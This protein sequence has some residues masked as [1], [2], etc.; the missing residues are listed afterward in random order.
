MCVDVTGFSCLVDI[1]SPEIEERRLVAKALLHSRA[2]RYRVLIIEGDDEM[3]ILA[4]KI[5]LSKVTPILTGGL[6]GL[7]KLAELPELRDDRDVKF[8][9]DSDY[10][11]YG[12]EP[13]VL[14]LDRE[15]FI[16]SEFHDLMTDL[17]QQNPS[18]MRNM[19]SSWVDEN[20]IGSR[21]RK[22]SFYGVGGLS[23]IRADDSVSPFVDDVILTA[24]RLANIFACIRYVTLKGG[25]GFP[26]K[27]FP[28]DYCFSSVD[29]GS[30]VSIDDIIE[31]WLRHLRAN[32]ENP[33]DAYVNDCYAE[34]ENL[35][36]VYYSS[37]H[38]FYSAL[39]FVLR[40]SGIRRRDSVI[41]DSFKL[42]LR[43]GSVDLSQV[44]WVAEVQHWAQEAE[45]E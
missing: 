3:H 41:R 15:D 13:Q 20:R 28:W 22:S 30:N 8:L 12:L 23:V 21:D 32:N 33:S 39:S 1:D 19:V 5:R 38:D 44:G 34:C 11:R 24:K 4:G 14:F 25:Y 37:D 10:G 43:A 7:L 40:M 29:S 36:R 45:T 26:C 6:R 2:N 9:A 17:H 18:I 27:S 35:S 42:V 31:G 16:L